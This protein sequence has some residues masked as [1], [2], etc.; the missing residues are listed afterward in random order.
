MFEDWVTSVFSMVL[1]TVVE[2][3]EDSTGD[4]ACDNCVEVKV[5]VETVFDDTV[6]VGA[7]D[8]VP[9]VT[10]KLPFFNPSEIQ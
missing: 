7:S 8:G 1:I 4:D 9:H 5:V 10:L 2:Y 6:V 3:I